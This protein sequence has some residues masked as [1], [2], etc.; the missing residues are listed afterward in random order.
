MSKV[1]FNLQISYEQDLG[2]VDVESPVMR[3]L[4]EGLQKEVW[5]SSLGKSNG[6]EIK[7]ILVQMHQVDETK[8]IN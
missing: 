1:V 8:N 6:I 7:K 5:L 3:E 2:D 4:L